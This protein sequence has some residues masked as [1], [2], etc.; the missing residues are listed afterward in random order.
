VTAKEREKRN[1]LRR[2]KAAIVFNIYG[3]AVL[4]DAAR[5]WSLD[6]IKTE[7]G[8]AI[9]LK[10]LYRVPA[11]QQT[12]SLTTK[13]KTYYQNFLFHRIQGAP[14]EK[15]FANRTKKR[16]PVYIDGKGMDVIGDEPDWMQ[17]WRRQ[18]RLTKW[19]RW[20]SK[21]DPQEFP[22]YVRNFIRMFNREAGLKQYRD[23]K[24]H[25]QEPRYGYAIVFEMMVE[26]WSEEAAKAHFK[27]MD[28][29]TI[30]RVMGGHVSA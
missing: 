26:G 20:S 23:E 29:P 6:R 4:A 9:D 12:E 24:G 25:W 27:P 19:R 17:L 21:N 7:L 1:N 14:S 10:R 8:I 18:S 28:D 5:S 16:M 30:Y 2:Y 11:R 13:R 3:N 22:P 15:A